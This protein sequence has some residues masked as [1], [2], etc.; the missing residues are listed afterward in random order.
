MEV[1]LVVLSRGM[2]DMLQ[3]TNLLVLSLGRLPF[4]DLRCKLL[5]L[6]V[7]F[8]QS[9]LQKFPIVQAELILLDQ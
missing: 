9:C 5:N 3:W 8:L 2:V 4:S 6:Y 1:A 7:T